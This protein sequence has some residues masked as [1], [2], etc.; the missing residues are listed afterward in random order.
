MPPK[1]SDIV[2]IVN[3][4]IKSSFQDEEF[5][6]MIIDSLSE[7]I[8]LKL[9]T[10]FD[11]LS[12]KFEV[13]N[14]RMTEV[15]GVQDTMANDVSK[16]RIRLEE[17][18]QQVHCNKKMRV[19]GLKEIENENTKELIAEMFK[20]KMKIGAGNDDLLSCY[21]VGSSDSV[22]RKP[23]PII[24]KVLSERVYNDILTNRKNLKNT[25]ITIHE[26]LTRSKLSLLKQSQ[27]KFGRKN[28]WVWKG[29]IFVKHGGGKFIIRDLADLELSTELTVGEV[30]AAA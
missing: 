12:L 21:R 23:R 20:T 18:E 9:Q 5:Q 3:S 1:Q 26:E 15:M 14:N 11:E 24:F 17:L 13:L 30:H 29:K 25:K 16:L 19:Y 10:R 28:T 27:E 6:K 7:K 8:T 22:S 2:A 4:T